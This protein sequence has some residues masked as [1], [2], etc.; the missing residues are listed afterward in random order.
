MNPITFQHTGLRTKLTTQ[1]TANLRQQHKTACPRIKASFLFQK[2]KI[3]KEKKA[4]SAAVQ[5][6]TRRL[7]RSKPSR[8]AVQHLG[9]LIAFIQ[10]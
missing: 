7:C 1:Q 5:L 3:E 8:E 2:K 10:K 4:R 9:L 6:P